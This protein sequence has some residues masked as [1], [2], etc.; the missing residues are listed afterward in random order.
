MSEPANIPTAAS[1]PDAGDSGNGKTPP[2]TDQEQF[3][4]V[5]DRDSRI[6]L[7]ILGGVAV[8]A[9]LIMSTVALVQSSNKDVETV[10][11]TVAAAGTSASAAGTTPQSTGPAQVI[12]F[13]VNGGWKKG[14]DGKLHDAFSQTEFNVKVG[15]TVELKVNNEDESAHSITS[16]VAGVNIM[17][18]PGVHTY[19]MVVKQAGHF[20]WDCIV[21]CDSEA[22]G[23]AMKHAGYMAGYITAT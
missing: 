11:Q 12:S 10:T 19:T 13:T 17:I 2:Q 1:P 15:Q 21:P 3:D 16:P 6:V 14:P 8:L 22:N 9:A 18:V 7:G 23:W 5:V 20:F 4:E